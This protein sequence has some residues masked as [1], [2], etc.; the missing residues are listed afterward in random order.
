MEMLR[1]H[2]DVNNRFFFLGYN[3]EKLSRIQIIFHDLRSAR[4]RKRFQK[5]TLSWSRSVWFVISVMFCVYSLPMSV[6]VFWGFFFF[7]RYILISKPAVWTAELRAQFL[8]GFKVFLKLLK[9]MQVIMAL[10]WQCLKVR[11]FLWSRCSDSY[12]FTAFNSPFSRGW[13]RW[14]GSLG[15]TLR[16]SQN[17]KLDSLS[18]YSSAIFYPCFKTGVPQK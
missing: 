7:V 2:Q 15:N 5:W 8:E 18:R 3:S 9:C 10:V 1:D 16:S 14:S 11:H 13:R 6:C 12:W 17:G 4:G